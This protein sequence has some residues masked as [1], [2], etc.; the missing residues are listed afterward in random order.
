MSALAS[1]FEVTYSAEQVAAAAE[2]FR[3]Y[4][5]K[6]YGRLLLLCCVINALGFALALWFGAP[7]DATMQFV[8]FVVVI[9]P[10]WLAY[11]YFAG[12]AIIAAK[13]RYVLAPAGRVTV[14]SAS[15]SLP[16]RDGKQL[17]LPWSRVKSVQE[18]ESLFLLIVSPLWAYFLPKLAMP[19]ALLEELRARSRSGAA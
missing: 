1:S 11:K 4:Q 16:T 6:R 15:V 5:F 14:G 2:V 7:L 8:A 18:A 3:D 17:E 10:V 9:G 19:A 13:L 12:P